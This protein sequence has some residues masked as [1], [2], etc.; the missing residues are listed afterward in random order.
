MQSF[1]IFI[2]IKDWVIPAFIVGIEKVGSMELYKSLAVTTFLFEDMK[3]KTIFI[4]HD[5]LRH[6]Y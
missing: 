2:N 6:F 4:V 5:Y 3:I 1:I